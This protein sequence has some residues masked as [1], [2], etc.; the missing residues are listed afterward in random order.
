MIKVGDKIVVTTCTGTKYEST[1]RTLN[2]LGKYIVSRVSEGSEV[3]IKVTTSG[4][5]YTAPIKFSRR[6]SKNV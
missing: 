5:P 2:Y 3:T 4:S 1:E 6:K